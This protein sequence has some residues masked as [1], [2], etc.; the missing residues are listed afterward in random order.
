MKETPGGANGSNVRGPRVQPYTPGA[1]TVRREVAQKMY[2]L[3]A[4]N[5]RFG[6]YEQAAALVVPRVNFGGSETNH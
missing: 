6:H 2:A 1:I 3:K 5:T 4:G